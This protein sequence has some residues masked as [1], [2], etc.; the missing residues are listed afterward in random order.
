MK[1]DAARFKIVPAN[2]TSCDGVAAIF[3]TRG[4]A[5]G[6]WC[7]RYKLK[8]REA[9]LGM[10]KGFGPGVAAALEGIEMVMPD[11]VYDGASTTLDLG[12]REVELRT[13]GLAHTR[14][15]QVVW[16]HPDW[17]SPEWIDFAVRYYASVA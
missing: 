1:A 12:G 16:L 7:Q 15:D 14:D 5:A 3:G 13:W 2:A 17:D 4:E 10:F 6:C 11:E 8:S 9:Y